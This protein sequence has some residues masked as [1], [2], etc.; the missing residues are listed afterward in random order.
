MGNRQAL[1]SSIKQARALLAGG[2]YLAAE[3]LG[4][5]LV[6]EHPNEPNSGFVL[7]LAQQTL[8]KH[9]HAATSLQAITE[10]TPN[11]GLAYL[12]LG[13]SLEI[14][15][16][17]HDAR[18]AFEQ[19]LKLLPK[20]ADSW[21]R[22][23]EIYLALGDKT[24]HQQAMTRYS[25][26]S[27]Q[28]PALNE[29][30]KAFQENDLN[31]A[32]SL[33]R[34]HIHQ[35]PR[36]VSAIRLLAEI[37]IR[38]NIFDDAQELLER[39][40]LLAPDFHLARVNYAHT[41]AKQERCQRALAE[42]QT[43]EKAQPELTAMAIEKAAVLVK[44]GQFDQAIALY[45]HL[46]TRL[47]QHLKLY[48]SLGHALKT[49]GK[50]G[51]A[52]QRYLQAIDIDAKNGEAWWSLADLKNYRFS[53]DQIETMAAL[54][55]RTLEPGSAAQIHFSLGKAFEDRQQSE[56]A[57][58]HY[59]LGNQIKQ[60]LDAWDAD[61]HHR[62]IEQ[63]IAATPSEIFSKRSGCDDPAPIF[64]VGLPRSGSTLLE[65]I[66]SSHSQ[67]DGTKELP[68]L[69]ALARQISGK[70]NRQDP[71]HYP[72]NL[73]TLSDEEC[74]ELGKSYLERTRVQRR[75]KPFFIDKMPN[76]FA[77]IALI[78]RILPEAKVID[79]RRHPMSTCFSCY[80]QHFA[81]GQTFTYRLEDLGRYYRDYL[82]LMN[83]WH[84][85]LPGQI[86]TVHYENVIQDFEAQV[87]E[88]LTF[89]QLPFESVCLEFYQ[90][91][92]AVRTASS[93][94]VRQ[95]LY[96]SGLDAWKPYAKNLQALLESLG[97]NLK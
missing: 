32:E 67:V 15:G 76:N 45:E 62:F 55:D 17:T 49:L 53:D 92:R 33:C 26:L 40:L 29:A 87:R 20:H 88:L 79:A 73:A 48:N 91:E 93:E 12:H 84:T 80:K 66:L 18:L 42:L 10:H 68:D 21:R 83:H 51:E 89:C 74:L 69:L 75:G 60:S 28:H 97:D 71:S 37:A 41:L 22:L 77:H 82:S 38:H 94:Q 57:F 95:P 11:F 13:Q 19:G 16:Q 96:K 39:C 70:K 30:V 85:V 90:T 3:S 1:Q 23:A 6:L 36:D 43:V 58:H 50:R 2:D 65:Q 54:C 61:E 35:H 27:G 52:E 31:R 25:E 46:L 81:S 56:R 86:L 72:E 7:A 9:K 59:H 44:L 8:G 4:Q 14:S 47:P 63:M 64:I 24:A 34:Q 78:K 5:R